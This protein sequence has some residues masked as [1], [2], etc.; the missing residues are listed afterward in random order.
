MEDQELNLI[1]LTADIV[2]A[3]V[4]NNNVSINDVATLVAKVHEALAGLGSSTVS[5]Q[6]ASE[7]Q[8]LEPAVSVR[9]SIKPESLTCLVC[10]RKQKTLKRHIANA[11]GMT[12]AQ[13]RETFGL[14]AD[15]PMV[16]PD[17]SARRSEMAKSIGLGQQRGQKAG[18]KAGKGRGRKPKESAE[19]G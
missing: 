9:S 5:G 15:Y 14:K 17:Y 2:A 16:A 1:E 6:Q 8:R 12:P 4:G 11:H 18:Q 10:A 7:E 13:Y 19:N 3:H